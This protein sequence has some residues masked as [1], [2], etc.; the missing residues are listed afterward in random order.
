M[1]CAA[2]GV[3]ESAHSASRAFHSARK[4]LARANQSSC[5]VSCDVMILPN[6][7]AEPHAAG[8]FRKTERPQSRVLALALGWAVFSFRT[9]GVGCSAL[10]GFSFISSSGLFLQSDTKPVGISHPQPRS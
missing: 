10:F 1:T 6:V 5:C 4:V 9:Q 2:A 3:N 7:T 8:D